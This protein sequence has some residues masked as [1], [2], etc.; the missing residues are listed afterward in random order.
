M[1]YIR[2]TKKRN[3]PICGKPDYCGIA[4]TGEFAICMR[5]ASDNQS[6]NGG[7]IHRLTF[8]DSKPK[9]KLLP[10]L[11]VPQVETVKR[12]PED[13]NEVYSAFLR[14]LVLST[15]HKNDLL[16]RGLAETDISLHGYKSM[17]AQLWANVL[18]ADLAENYDLRGV[19]GFYQNQVTK[20]WHFIDYRNATG[21]LIPIRNADYDIVA[22]QLRRDDAQ[23]PKYLLMSSAWHSYGASSGVPP[24]FA[25]LGICGLRSSF[26][27]VIVTEGALK[28]NIIARYTGEPTVG[29]VGVGCFTDEFPHQLLKAFPNLKKVKI[30]YDMDWIHNPAVK[31]QR[32]RLEKTLEK[33]NI[34][35][36]IL[37]WNR[38]YKGLDDFLAAKQSQITVAA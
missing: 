22:L 16:S 13:L 17:P 37:S 14:D 38:E 36:R 29:L 30:A 31:V 35:T 8:D 28:A 7:Y 18:C 15:G 2:V 21:Y 34:E 32:V 24:H 3:C 23:K 9:P 20:K 11:E 26:S 4:E 1:K 6:A 25:I 19:P 27:S 5:V 10:K 12:T 33:I